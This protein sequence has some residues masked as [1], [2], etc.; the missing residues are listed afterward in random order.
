M[1]PEVI[2]RRNSASRVSCVSYIILGICA[3]SSS[4]SDLF[5]WL[6][7]PMALRTI[8]D[9]YALPTHSW[10]SL[11][12]LT[13]I[14]RKRKEQRQAAV[15]MVT[16]SVE[17]DLALRREDTLLCQPDPEDITMSKRSWEYAY[18]N[19]KHS[20]HAAA[21]IEYERLLESLG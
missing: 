21:A 12:E 13:E 8:L 14:V 15:R 11:N 6:A 10:Q 4:S 9:T 19:W 16:S 2:V 7:R 3:A 5:A 1:A 17:Y 18:M 20:V